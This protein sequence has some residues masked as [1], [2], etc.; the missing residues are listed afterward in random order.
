MAKARDTI[1]EIT[2]IADEWRSLAYTLNPGAAAEMDKK[3]QER[4]WSKKEEQQQK[5][6]P[7]EFEF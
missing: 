4:Y 2:K 3:I 1:I 6:K 5:Q 7:E